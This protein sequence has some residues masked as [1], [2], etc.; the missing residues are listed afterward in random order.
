MIGVSVNQAAAALLL[1]ENFLP[2]QDVGVIVLISTRLLATQ[3][4][5]GGAEL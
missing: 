5:W 3:A 1:G 2:L 4:D